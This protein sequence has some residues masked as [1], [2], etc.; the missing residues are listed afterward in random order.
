[1]GTWGCSPT[2]PLANGSGLVMPPMYWHGSLAPSSGLPHLQQPSLLQPPPGLPI[3]HTMQTPLSISWN[4]SIF[5]IWISNF[6]GASSYVSY[7]Y[8]S[9]NLTLTASPLPSM[10]DPSSTN[11]LSVE[12]SS[13]LLPD[14][15]PAASSISVCVPLVPPL[16]FN[17]EKTMAT[18]QSTPVVGSKPSAVPGSTLAYGSV[19]E[20]VPAVVSS[21]SSQVEKPVA[22]ETQNHSLQTGHPLLPSSQP[23]Q[24]SHTDADAKALEDKSMAFPEPSSR[25]DKKNLW[26]FCKAS[27][28]P[29]GWAW[30]SRV[31]PWKGGYGYTGYGQPH[32]AP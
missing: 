18:P 16:T 28:R 1:M 11:I 27:T 4:Q 8:T 20:P 26:R 29:R 21:S 19:L 2:P 6:V 9:A 32:R 14:K 3:P 7:P 31:L 17:L 10:L 15:S 13:T 25:K 22:I 23:M 30:L 5:T 24:T 12:A